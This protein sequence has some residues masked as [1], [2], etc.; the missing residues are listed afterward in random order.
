MLSIIIPIVI[1]VENGVN[2]KMHMT[3]CSFRCKY[4]VITAMVRAKSKRD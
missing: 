1:H 3:A 4:Y 2:F